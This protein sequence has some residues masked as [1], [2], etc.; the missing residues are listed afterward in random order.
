MAPA[1]GEKSKPDM[2]FELLN[3]LIALT[4][5]TDEDG[6]TLARHVNRTKAWAD[7]IAKMFYDAIEENPATA[8][9]L[10]PGERPEREAT[11]KKWYLDIT[12]GRYDREFW[13]RQW[14]VGLVHIQRN[15]KNTMLLAMLSRMQ[16]FFLMKSLMS[17]NAQEAGRLH[18]AFQR[19]SDIAGA[20]IAESSA[21]NF[22]SAMEDVS[23]Y[24]YDHMKYALHMRIGTLIQEARREIAAMGEPDQAKS[25]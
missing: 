10:L 21:S 17:L 1:L 13:A 22:Q 11:L 25:A 4:G 3:E 8:T 16:Q 9:V 24:A 12:S 18:L 2:K 15:V 19:V 5:Y 23:G 6:E 20:L 14:L 7:E